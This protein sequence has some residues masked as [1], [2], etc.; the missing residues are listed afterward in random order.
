MP[1]GLL[2]PFPGSLLLSAVGVRREGLRMPVIGIGLGAQPG[3]YYAK[4]KKERELSKPRTATSESTKT[5]P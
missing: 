4:K 5:P 1:G 2:P 3:P